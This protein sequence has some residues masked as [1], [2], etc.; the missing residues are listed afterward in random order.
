MARQTAK[1]GELIEKLVNFDTTSRES[2]LALIGFI[3]DYLAG[4]GV[5]STLIHDGTGKKANLYATLGP[6]DRPGIMLSG[7]TDVVPVD[8]QD[9]SSDP[10]TLRRKDARLYGRGTCDMKG[11]IAI[12][13]AHAPEFLRRGLETPI[14]LAF[15]YDEEI[16]CIGVHGLIEMINGLPIKPRMAIIGE[17]TGMQVIVAHKGKTDSIVHVRGFECHSSLAPQ[18]VNAIQY[19]AELIAHLAGKSAQFA[20]DGPFDPEFDLPH[21]TIHTGVVEG[22]T[23]LNIVPRDCRFEFE[24]RNLPRDDPGA[25]LDEIKA[26]AEA[27]LVPRM[28][29]VAAESG[30]DFEPGLFYPGLDTRPDE[31]VVTLAKALA[32]QNSHAKVAFGTEAGLFQQ[33]AGIPCVVCGPGSIAQAHKPDEYLA[34]D[35]I[36]E[37]ET[38]MER[39]AD[40]VCLK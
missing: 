30:I 12:V 14:H 22:G 20:K 5:E 10:F 4:L 2:N 39:L 24:I 23:V 3:G 32:G 34:L 21:T 36:A 16:G 8:G 33:D 7:H 28:Q 15:S 25:I 11:F 35:Q 18:G 1:I 17:P 37:C 29:A 13:L 6:T 27:E 26:Y 40:R 38:F 19:A 9:W 31:E